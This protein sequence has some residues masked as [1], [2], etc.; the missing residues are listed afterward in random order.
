MEICVGYA[1]D[2]FVVIVSKHESIA[3]ILTK[4]EKSSSV[5]L[6]N[7]KSSL[8]SNTKSAT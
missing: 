8:T 2:R 3:N 6:R 5:I 4:N 1:D 7:N